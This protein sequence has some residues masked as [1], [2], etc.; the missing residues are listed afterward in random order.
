MILDLVSIITNNCLNPTLNCECFVEQ[1]FLGSQSFEESLVSIIMVL[2]SVDYVT[3]CV[4]LMKWNPKFE[5]STILCKKINMFKSIIGHHLWNKLCVIDNTDI[6][7]CLVN[8]CLLKKDV[9]NTILQ[10][11]FI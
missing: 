10:M 8:S 11:Y 3:S 4:S 7:K 1:L 6:I 9:Y 5:P 2:G